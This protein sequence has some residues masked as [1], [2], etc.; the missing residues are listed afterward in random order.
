[1]VNDKIVNSFAL[2]SIEY[3]NNNKDYYDMVIPFVL[4]IMMEKINKNNVIAIK[5]IET[6]LEERFGI[7]LPR[8]VVESILR[9][10]T[11]KQYGYVKIENGIFYNTDKRFDKADF[12][13]KKDEVTKHQEYVLSGLK[14]F[15]D[16]NYS[17]F[18]YD[19]NT[20]ENTMISFLCKYG[21]S[22]LSYKNSISIINNIKNDMY[23]YYIGKYIVYTKDND[24]KVFEYIR[25]IVKGAM[26]SSA[27]YTNEDIKNFKVDKKITNLSVYFDTP[28]IIYLLGVSGVEYKEAVEELVNILKK[29][30]VNIFS[31]EHI[32]D[33]VE[34]ILDAYVKHYNANSLNKTYNF[35]Y[36]IE[37]KI[38][39]AEILLYKSNIR[40][41]LN[42]YGIKIEFTPQVTP[43][44]NT[45]DWE[46][47]EE[48]LES[49]LQYKTESRRENDI[50]SICSMYI[51][52]SRCDL[53]RL[54]NCESIFI[55][56]NISLSRIMQRYFREKENRKDFPAVIDDSYFTSMVWLKASTPSDKL[57]T[58]KLIADALATQEVPD[59][60]WNEYLQQIEKING[61]SPL[62]DA[63]LY[64][65]KY[66][67][68]I[69]KQ[70][71]EVASGDVRKI[72]HIDIAKL[73]EE[74]DERRHKKIIEERNQYK[75]E[76]DEKD[77]QIIKEKAIKYKK[78]FQLWKIP[79][80][81]SKHML[82]I[83]CIFIVLC[84]EFISSIINGNI[85]KNI[86]YAGATAIIIVSVINKVLDKWISLKK[87]QF[88]ILCTQCGRRILERKIEKYDLD[89]KDKIIEYIIK[90]NKYFEMYKKSDEVESQDNSEQTSK[91][92]IL[93]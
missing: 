18:E 11:N 72:A 75:A 80:I 25:E 60:F 2:M 84:S 66:D 49:H 90:D 67:S 26:L 88:S 71:Y 36:L 54:E 46:K 69:K 64:K 59:E 85:I 22:V 81:M 51:N 32:I 41:I 17:E 86:P 40:E 79:C 62:D 73:I 89:Y 70:V 1:M 83:I 44:N 6:K 38:K 10:L 31:F 58:L 57:P 13:K 21:S 42:E 30:G 34:G 8:N 16:S 56:T 61:L 47:A 5:Q 78:G 12:M 74:D 65:L 27:F 63:T 55:T 15:I 77:K 4:L 23:S 92:A 20:L 52:R 93:N 7:F 50:K 37:N 35:D 68:F 82:I 28:L 43:A 76:R 29:L 48:Y 33:E 45:I 39:P 87:E 53:L 19:T 9:R 14:K 3:A 24:K 91:H